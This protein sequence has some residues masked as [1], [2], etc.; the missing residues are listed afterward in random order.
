MGLVDA[1]NQVNFYDGKIR[2]VDPDGQGIREVPRAQY[3]DFIAEHVEPWSYMKF[4]YL[5][6]VGW[7]GFTDGPAAAST[8]SRRSPGSTP[9][10]AWRR[11]R[12]SRPTR[13]S[14]TRWAES[15]STTRWPTTGPA[16][17]RCSRRPRRCVELADDP[18]TD[19]QRHPDAPDREADGRRRRRRGPPR[20]A[21]PP[22]RDGRARPHHQGE[23]HRRD[24]EQRGT[25]RDER[26]QGRQ[27][28]DPRRTR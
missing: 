7:N 15:P 21:H 22:L 19:R 16:S 27:G 3:L 18:G 2:V 11:P 9:P 13:S 17:S 28:T 6:P 4:C 24:A 10:T 12:R 25:H 1:N 14:S 26:R 23:P 8:P 5:K 20:H